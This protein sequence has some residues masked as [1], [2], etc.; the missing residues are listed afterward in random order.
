[1]RRRGPQ[2]EPVAPEQVVILRVDYFENR[3]GRFLS[4]EAKTRQ[5]GATPTAPTPARRLRCPGTAGQARRSTRRRGYVDE[6]GP[7]YHSPHLRRAPR[8]HSNRRAGTASPP[9]PS[10]VRVARATATRRG[11]RADLARRRPAPD[12]LDLHEG[13]H[14]QYMDP[15]ESTPVRGARRRVPEHQRAGHA[16]VQDE[17][18]PAPRSGDDGRY[19]PERQHAARRPAGGRGGAHLRAWGHEGGND[20]SAEFRNPARRA[21][22]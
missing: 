19:H 18:L 11:R 9:R 5:G 1:M 10:R 13:L 17:R 21:R 20:I 3:D 15:T 2:S 14:D 7:G 22:R 6:R 4:V 8:A 12:E 16:A